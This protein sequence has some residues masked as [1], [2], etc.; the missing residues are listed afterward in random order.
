MGF[1]REIEKV[2][3]TNLDSGLRYISLRHAVELYGGMSFTDT[4][5]AICKKCGIA[6]YG[7]IF[8]SENFNVAADFLDQ[9]HTEY[10]ESLDKLRNKRK[11]EKHQ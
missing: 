8:S 5:E 10:V 9:L 1:S 4:W 2:R 7:E 3:D 11:A 6:T